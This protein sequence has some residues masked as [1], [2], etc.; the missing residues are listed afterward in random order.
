VE[1]FA[2]LQPA[3]TKVDVIVTDHVMPGV[4]WLPC[5]FVGCTTCGRKWPLS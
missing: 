5:S 4:Q 1:A 3:A 2:F